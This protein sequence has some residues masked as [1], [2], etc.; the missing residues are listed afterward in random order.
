VGHS[1]PKRRSSLQS[2][3]VDL[4]RARVA[5]QPTEARRRG[6]RFLLALGL[7][8][9]LDRR[10]EAAFDLGSSD[11]SRP[12]RLPDLCQ[13]AGLQGFEVLPDLPPLVSPLG[14]AEKVVEL[15]GALPSQHPPLTLIGP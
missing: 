2:L 7:G 6:A 15:R 3:E 5:D 14:R 1:N 8:A 9:G 4:L 11:I 13:A 12:T 10:C